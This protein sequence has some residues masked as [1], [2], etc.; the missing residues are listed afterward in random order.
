MLSKAYIYIYIYIYI[1]RPP[2]HTIFF[3]TFFKIKLFQFYSL[4]FDLLK[5]T[6]C[7]FCFYFFI[8]LSLFFFHNFIF[9]EFFSSNF[10]FIFLLLSFF[11]R[12]F[13]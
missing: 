8:G 2:R 4:T 7:I 9:Y 5:I 10:I 13:F 6:L 3:E 1:Y 12:N 11:L